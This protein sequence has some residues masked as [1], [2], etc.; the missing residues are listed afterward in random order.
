[1]V[2]SDSALPW[3]PLPLLISACLLALAAPSI[4]ISRHHPPSAY[5]HAI[6]PSI[7]APTA[8]L[9]SK[10]LISSPS[11]PSFPQLHQLLRHSRLQTVIRTPAQTHPERRTQRFQ[12]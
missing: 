7:P 8:P 5:A 3:P 1:M 4:H 12:P 11:S 9:T 6:S 2:V 10:V